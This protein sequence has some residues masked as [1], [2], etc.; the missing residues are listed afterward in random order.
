[1]KLEELTCC[2]RYYFGDDSPQDSEFWRQEQVWVK[3]KLDD[4]DTQLS[5]WYNELRNHDLLEWA[6]KEYPTTPNTLLGL[7]LSRYLHYITYESRI[8]IQEF[9]IYIAKEYCKQPIR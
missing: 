5:N 6:N 4:N 1:M 8:T 9:K 7:L 3:A 2:C